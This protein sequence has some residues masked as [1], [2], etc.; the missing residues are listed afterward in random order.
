MF[1][2][3]VLI[4]ISTLEWKTWKALRRSCLIWRCVCS[5][6][7]Y[8]YL[9]L[10]PGLFFP[11]LGFTPSEVRNVLCW[12][13]REGSVSHSHLE[14]Q[15][16]APCM[17]HAVKTVCPAAFI[18][19][20]HWL[21]GSCLVTAGKRTW[22]RPV[23]SVATRSP[24]GSEIHP[25]GA[26]RFRCVCRGGTVVLWATTRTCRGARLKAL[27][28]AVLEF[29]EVPDHSSKARARGGYSGVK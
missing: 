3:F 24:H 17:N 15:K 7:W 2:V 12:S 11:L 21:Q 10:S 22:T 6:I 29:G 14:M 26:W 23:A 4:N 9:L 25:W 19:N 20:S 1:T 28:K 18:Q 8:K 5:L 13:L 16:L 27:W